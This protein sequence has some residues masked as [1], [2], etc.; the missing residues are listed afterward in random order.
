MIAN[1]YYFMMVRF[2]HYYRLKLGWKRIIE[3]SLNQL[4]LFQDYESLTSD[5]FKEYPEAKVLIVGHTHE[6]M[7]REY[8]DG[9]RFI[10]T[11]TWTR[12]V[13]LDLGQ[14]S[15]ESQLTFAKIQIN[16]LDYDL[17]SFEE[18]VDI[19]LNKWAPKT[20]LPYEDFR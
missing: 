5:F 11:G 16:N 3:E 18:H 17:D 14:L 20:D 6:P 1:A 12:M 15:N 4:H 7:F 19:D 9:T 8:A 13:N 2:L 10:N